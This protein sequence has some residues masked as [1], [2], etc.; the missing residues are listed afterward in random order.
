MPARWSARRH[1]RQIAMVWVL[2]AAAA[3]PAVRLTEQFQGYSPDPIAAVFVQMLSSGVPWVLALPGFVWLSRRLPLG[4]GNTARNLA[5]LL[6][7]GA[8]LTPVLTAGG[9]LAAR[10][11]RMATSGIPLSEAFGTL[12]TAIFVT[13]LFALPTY[14]A[15]VGVGQ[16][17]A[18]F[19]RYQ[20][21]ER[22]LSRT[23]A[24]ALRAQI[25]PHFL[26]NTLNAISALGYRNPVQADRAMVQL[27]SLLRDVLNRPSMVPLSEEIAMVAD[28]V[29]LHRLL[30]DDR[31]T[32][33][34]DVSPDA[35]R[36]RVPAMLLQ[37]LVENAIVHGLSRLSE[38][39]SLALSV[40][41]EGG[42]LQVDIRNDAPL[43]GGDPGCG[44]GLQ[45][46]RDRLAAAYGEKAGLE[47]Q[48]LS[49][50]ARATV[51]LPF[52]TVPL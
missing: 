25:A 30:L 39:G 15:M 7:A 22:L 18:Y 9:V 32:F 41:R 48:H 42:A 51:C 37:P 14:V 43:S 28:Y 17:I 31:L 1:W 49:A 46:V 47:F 2:V 24:A 21:R 6:L 36:A 33:D 34:L 4:L 52:E 13:T 35:W 10:S 40:R 29:D 20:Q 26:F 3:T 19:E 27:S 8:V 5:V 44:I 50:S 16:T 11:V 38:G 12:G 45:N 23:R